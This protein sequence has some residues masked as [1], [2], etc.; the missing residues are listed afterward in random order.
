MTDNL[1]LTAPSLMSKVCFSIETVLVSFAFLNRCSLRVELNRV[2]IKVVFPKPLSPKNYEDY[3]PIDWSPTNYQDIENIWCFL[4][5][6]NH[7]T[8]DGI[9]S[10]VQLWLVGLGYPCLPRSRIWKLTTILKC[11]FLWGTL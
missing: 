9:D 8:W 10:H 4:E 3:P 1:I 5:A 6:M 2:F 7:L 11:V